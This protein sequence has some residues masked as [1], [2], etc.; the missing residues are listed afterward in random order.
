[1]DKAGVRLERL[2]VGKLCLLLDPHPAAAQDGSR[3]EAGPGAPLRGHD[4]RY[5]AS[6][7]LER[8]LFHGAELTEATKST[9][10]D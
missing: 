3:S 4:E 2:G 5:V 10:E 7:E 1:M 9:V 6:L 8:L